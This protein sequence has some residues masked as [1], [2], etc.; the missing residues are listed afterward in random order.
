[1][2]SFQ[3]LKNVP[4]LET[5]FKLDNIYIASQPTEEAFEWI[6]SKSISK[7]INLRDFD[8]MDFNFEKK[9]CSDA[10]IEYHQFPVTLNGK[11]ITENLKKLNNLVKNNNENYLIHCGSANRVIAWLLTY[12]PSHKN[13]SFKDAEILTRDMGLTNENFINEARD[14][15]LTN[16]LGLQI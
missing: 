10:K 2:L 15:C 1:M 9:L 14:L 7:V 13:I 8:E 6:T 4:G 5:V 3:K 12:L 11:L 16:P